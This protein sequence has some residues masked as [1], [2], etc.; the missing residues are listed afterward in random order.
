M[1]LI[2]G[3]EK[4]PHCGC[5]EYYRDV[6]MSGRTEYYHRFDDKFPDNSQIHDCLTYRE[7]KRCFCVDC[8][9]FL[10]TALV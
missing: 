9:K 3:L 10:G 8:Y 4:C 1:G 2:T 6:R 7:N 5:K